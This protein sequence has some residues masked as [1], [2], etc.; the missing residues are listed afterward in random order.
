[1][2][3]EDELLM[4][5]TEVMDFN[6]TMDVEEA[7]RRALKKSK[8]EAGII[9]GPGLS[10]QT[11]GIV[12]S[13]V[14]MTA[15]SLAVLGGGTDSSGKNVSMITKMSQSM[16][17]TGGEDAIRLSKERSA[18]K[19][20]HELAKHKASSMGVTHKY[21]PRDAIMPGDDEDDGED[22]HTHGHGHVSGKGSNS[23]NGKHEVE[24]E[25]H[26]SHRGTKDLAR[27]AHAA[28]A[29]HDSHAEAHLGTSH[30]SS[31]GKKRHRRVDYDEEE[32]AE[33]EVADEQ[34]DEFSAEKMYLRKQKKRHAEAA[35][36]E[37]DDTS[38]REHKSTH[39]LSR[40]ELHKR[41]PIAFPNH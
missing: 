14:T 3:S 36:N 4:Q 30:K 34:D 8:K 12:A 35:R 37:E 29:A 32:E 11:W 19:F 33:D 15:L 21:K 27:H 16:M 26:T 17:S 24:E 6:S 39:N 1:M 18:K 13:L 38:P 22:G 20:E 40:K 31:S 25:T 41:Y 10:W 9:E 5:D 2:S 28:P 7:T 23:G